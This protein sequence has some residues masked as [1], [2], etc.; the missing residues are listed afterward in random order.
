MPG[1]AHDGEVGVPEPDL[2]PHVQQRGDGFGNVEAAVEAVR[3]SDDTGTQP[4]LG[5]AHVALQSSTMST[6]TRRC[7]LTAAVLSTV[8]NAIAVRP[9]RPIT[10]P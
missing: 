8:R 3:A 4:V 1:Q 6:N 9:P 2:G 7:S 5:L 10:L